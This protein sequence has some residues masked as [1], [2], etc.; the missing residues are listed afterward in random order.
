MYVYVY[1][2]IYIYICY[3]YIYIYTHSS[4]VAGNL[5]TD[6]QALA[7]AKEAMDKARKG[8]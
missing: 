5:E 4:Q 3:I 1:V 7:D 2:H 8:G 6:K